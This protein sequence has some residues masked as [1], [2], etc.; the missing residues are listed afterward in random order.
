MNT[1]KNIYTES[2]QAWD[3][4]SA[5]VYY[6]IKVPKNK[7]L[8]QVERW[9][10]DYYEKRCYCAGDC[11]GHWFGQANEVRKIKR[12]RFVVAASYARNY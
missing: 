4:E 7:T 6:L 5:S 3:N 8:K 10:W 9:A 12:G 2:I 1:T 11:C